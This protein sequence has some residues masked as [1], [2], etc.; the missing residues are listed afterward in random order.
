MKDYPALLANLLSAS[1]ASESPPSPGAVEI[2]ELAEK[3]LQPGCAEVPDAGTWRRYL[4]STGCSAFVHALPGR[5]HRCRWAETAF[6]AVLRSGYSLEDMLADRV[7]RHPER[8]LFRE[9][10]GDVQSAWTYAQVARRLRILAGLL[11]RT[12]PEPR[13]AIFCENSIDSACC[14]LACLVHRIFDAPLNVHFDVPALVP[15]FD[16]LRINVAL[17][18]T[19]ERITRLQE[20]RSRAKQPFRI[21]SAGTPAA[22]PH[23]PVAGIEALEQACARLD[24]DG[25]D[26]LLARRRN[27]PLTEVATAMF[28]SGSTGT[29][30]GIAFTHYHLV[31]KRFARAAALPAVGDREVLLCYLPLYHTFGRYLELLGTIYWGGTYVFAGN[32]S[33]ET[34]ISQLQQ[35][36]PTGLISVPVRWTQIRDYCL[37]NT[38]EAVFPAAQDAVFRGIVGD[39]LRWG[40]SAAGYLDP[41]VFRF[42]QRFGVDLCSGFGM[43]EATGG[44][45]MTPSGRYLDGT[46]G[47]ALPGIRLRFGAQGELEI[48]GPYVA[49]YID[50]K[51]DGD[52][53][54]QDPGE[55]YWLATGDLFKIHSNGYLEIVDRIKDIY[56]N[57]RGQTI[58]PR[59]V[60][61]KFE[62]VPGIKRVFLVGDRRDSNVLLIVPDREDKV[63]QVPESNVRDYLHQIVAAANADLAPYERVVNFEVL[64][65]DFE[66]ARRELTAKGSYRRKVIEEDFREVIEKLYKGNYVELE[67]GE[68]LVRIPRW[69]FRD[70]GLLESDIVV[71][72][73]ELY[74]PGTR[75]RLPIGLRGGSNSALVGDLEY[76]LAG[77][78]V[79]IGLFA[80]QPRLWLG[81][82]ALAAFCPCKDGWDLPLGS[83]SPQVRLPWRD[84]QRRMD[85]NLEPSPSVRDSRLRRVHRLCMGALFLPEDTALAA[86]ERLG[87]QLKISDNRLASVI[88]RRLEA[89]A[90]HPAEAV[91][92]LAYRILLTDEP[93]PD[94]SKVFP[95]FIES[96]LT[97]LNE[98]SI[99]SL[100]GRGLGDKRL[101]ALRRR[102]FSYRTQLQ[103]PAS[104]VTR[105][106]FERI[107]DLL[108]NFAR[109]DMAFFGPVRAELA[110]WALHRADPYLVQAAENRLSLLR[111]WF[112]SVLT[113]GAAPAE[114]SDKIIIDDSLSRVSA[115]RIEKILLDPIFLKESI[116][117][118]FDEPDFDLGRVA[119]GGIWVSRISTQHQ[120]DIYR[121]GINL[122]SGKHYD[123]LLV[124]GDDFT[125]PQVRDTLSWHMALSEHPSMATVL[126][127]FGA[128][129]PDLGVMSVA[130]VSD[131]TVWE[132]VREYA[133]AYTVHAY[134]PT[135]HD[136]R[137]FFVRGMAAFLA[138]WKS[139]G[140]RI[141][142]GAVTPENV[143]VPDAD[144]REG[145]CILSLT[146]WRNFEGPLCLVLPFVRNFYRQTTAYYPR[147]LPLLEINWIFDACMEAL[148]PEEGTRFLAR[149]E[150]ELSGGEAGA[151]R[152]EVAAA[153]AEY[154]KRLLEEPYQPLP[155]L[156]AVDR[157][158]EW[159][160]MNPHATATAREEEVEQLYWLYRLDRFHSMSR[161]QLYRRTFFANAGAPVDAAFD[162]LLQRMFRKPGISPIH[163]EE[164]SDLQAALGDPAARE[165]FSRMVFPQAR[166]EQRLEIVAVGE[167]ERKQV[168]VRSEITDRRGAHYAV[169]E[170]VAP[171]EIG[172]LYRLLYDA[173]Y[174][175]QISE[176]DRYLVVLDDADQVLGGLTYKPQDKDV[177]YLSGL[178]VAAPLKGRGL[179]SA[180][181]EDFC[182]RMEAR[183]VRLVKTD[184]FLRHFY[185]A[186]GFHVDE[187]W[188]GLVR[189]LRH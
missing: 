82:P 90:R 122:R 116:L 175:R 23:H 25:L 176:Q 13:V 132:K 158:A 117:L 19:E 166:G 89:L 142:P 97:F 189:E 128:C 181:L 129:R 2:L 14:D 148:G 140:E 150:S 126:P 106:Q 66:L 119:P 45:T 49:R 156:C 6:K 36:R 35:V 131:L 64:E 100:A 88:R 77:P 157:Y 31:T 84:A 92:C 149:L 144:F 32:P 173:E 38:R 113:A 54:P 30:K 141:I 162:R 8:I 154:R 11:C 47:I 15:I 134:F 5:E 76:Q 105:E 40:L 29:P 75:R 52:L 20:V 183:G 185:S 184:F 51:G 108:W 17:A 48:A 124:V 61:R 112:E 101:L 3:M 10:S 37:E 107:F 34:L 53:P 71:A 135:R 7:R 102:L 164:L 155:L 127:R 125:T 130:Y 50:E 143:V 21:F 95:A 152:A 103:W 163:L 98:E 168:I 180:L 172:Q 59:R 24:L 145:A 147:V 46:V 22:E 177:L 9:A 109:Q 62:G 123:L 55:D 72:R 111:D 39:R 78:V 110:S 41:K 74:C 93:M 120:F 169:R 179:A 114:I 139:S 121:V 1:S 151:E 160:Q 171:A 146:G 27:K 12:E 153:L 165:V 43:T 85:V 68:L 136:W 56:K 83:I 70:L 80:R 99:R 96:G 44:V 94:Y 65:R 28:T 133:A 174:P 182:V 188:G 137:R 91:R 33:V 186:N 86:V 57:N 159:E 58:A 178:V 170:P 118:A 79:D 69:F 16:R 81:N 18:D 115:G 63:L 73:G 138:V 26:E 104:P 60:E 87:E 42:F 187:R 67:C 4:D 161:Y 167:S